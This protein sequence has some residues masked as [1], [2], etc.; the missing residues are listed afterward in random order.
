MRGAPPGAEASLSVRFRWASSES[1]G[2][3]AAEDEGA[4]DDAVAAAAT[5]NVNGL[6]KRLELVVY[7]TKQES[8]TTCRRSSSRHSHTED[9]GNQKNVG[10]K[11]S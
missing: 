5:P 2:G 6:C 9:A 4:N 7:G 8:D 10:R 1:K 11:A 3:A